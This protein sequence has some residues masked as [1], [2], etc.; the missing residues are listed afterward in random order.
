MSLCLGS[1]LFKYILQCT[2]FSSQFEF[3]AL[4]HP[5]DALAQTAPMWLVKHFK[6]VR[7]SQRLQA[8]EQ[9]LVTLCFRQRGHRP[10]VNG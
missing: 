7:L 2:M 4:P 1:K 5:C 6:E 8:I 9:N 3:R 10:L